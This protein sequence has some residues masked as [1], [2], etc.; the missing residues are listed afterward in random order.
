VHPTGGSLRVFKQFSWLKAGSVK[1]ALSRP[2]HQRVTLTVGRLTHDTILNTM[3]N[4]MK[5]GWWSFELPYYRPH[6]KRGTY[7]LFSYQDLPSI[8]ENLDNS[9]E[10]LKAQSIKEDS[11]FEGSYADGSKPDLRK[12]A[13]IASETDI[14]LPESFVTF[15][16]ST[17][18]HQR[19][20]SCTDCYLDVGDYAV[21]TKGSIEGYLL[22][23]L[24]D[25]QWVLHWYIHTDQHGNHFIVTSLNAYGFA[26]ED[27]NGNAFATEID[28]QEE[29]IWFCA[30]SFT[31]FMY[32]FW[33]E[34]EI[35]FAL[36]EEERPLTKTEQA[37]VDRYFGKA[38]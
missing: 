4:K 25:S 26:F 22:H 3:I 14:N 16:N 19:I 6:L 24:S 5:T 13:R 29:D 34:N 10:W 36:A 7:S 18:L 12:L 11:L 20:R 28:I 15:M 9:F 32:R 21:K 37:Y 8:V 17:E 38:M 2:A 35:W 31:E 33:L 23:F 30:P 1:V 27:E